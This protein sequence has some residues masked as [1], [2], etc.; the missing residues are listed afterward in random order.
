[1]SEGNSASRRPAA[2]GGR[3]ARATPGPSTRLGARLRRPRSRDRGDRLSA[4]RRRRPPDRRRGHVLGAQAGVTEPD[5]RRDAAGGACAS[6]CGARAGRSPAPAR[7]RSPTAATRRASR[8][9]ARDGTIVILDA[10]TGR[11]PR[12]R[13]VPRAAPAGHP[14][15]SPA[16]GPHPGPRLLRAALPE[17]LRGPRVGPAV[18]DT[19]SAHAPDALPVAA[20]LPGPAARRRGASSSCTTCRRATS[21]S[22]GWRSAPRL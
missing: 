6:A 7:T 14:A 21:R 20:A 4:A 10:G 22:A 5:L 18:D 1:M 2:A 15:D 8:S 12:R 16:H 19:G 13:H 17:G 3:A 11:A 9:R